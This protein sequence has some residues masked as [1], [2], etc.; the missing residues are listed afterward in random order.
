MFGG[1]FK[2]PLTSYFEDIELFSFLLTSDSRRS[3][4]FSPNRRQSFNHFYFAT[5]FTP[6]F[7]Y[8]VRIHLL[9]D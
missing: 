7:G 4:I 5:L 9:I 1:F 6:L 8:S 2:I 3:K